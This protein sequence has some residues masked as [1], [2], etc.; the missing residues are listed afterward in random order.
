MVPLPEMLTFW[1]IMHTGPK[2]ATS[3]CLFW[4]VSYLWVLM[5]TQKLGVAVAKIY[6][7]FTR[8][9]PPNIQH[10][11]LSQNLGRVPLYIGEFYF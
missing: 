7:N 1:P 9:L 3:Y 11:F 5:G 2:I 6:L 4:K 10:L 8:S